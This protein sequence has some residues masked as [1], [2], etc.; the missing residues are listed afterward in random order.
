MTIIS[1]RHQINSSMTMF[2]ICTINGTRVRQGN[3]YFQMKLTYITGNSKV[4]L[5]LKIYGIN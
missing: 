4:I 2:M 1:I 5:N 3:T